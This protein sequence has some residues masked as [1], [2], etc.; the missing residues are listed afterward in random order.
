ML[1]CAPRP[2]DGLT[3]TRY[4][5]GTFIIPLTI[6][7][8]DPAREPVTVSHTLV[9]DPAQPFVG[10]SVAVPPPK[11]AGGAGLFGEL[12]GTKPKLKPAETKVTTINGTSYIEKP[13]PK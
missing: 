7:F 2:S 10:T 8:T 1:C 6:H 4:G 11:G 13:A 9:L 3:L 5:W 12:L